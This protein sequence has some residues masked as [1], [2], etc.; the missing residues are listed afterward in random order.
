MLSEKIQKQ[1]EAYLKELTSL[2]EELSRAKAAQGDF[3]PAWLVSWAHGLLFLGRAYGMSPEP[4]DSEIWLHRS[5]VCPTQKL[6]ELYGRDPH[7][8]WT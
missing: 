4:N 1:T 3:A 5:L 8:A 7:A 6:D 2:R